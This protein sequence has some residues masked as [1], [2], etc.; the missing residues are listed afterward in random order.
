MKDFPKQPMNRLILGDCLDVMQQLRDSCLDLVYIDPPFGTGRELTG[1]NLPLA[2][3]GRLRSPDSKEKEVF[4]LM[5]VWED[6]IEGYIGWLEPRLREMARLLKPT[7]SLLVHLDWHASH[8]VK[9]LLDGIM[10]KNR[11][12]NEI[13]WHYKT[14]GHPKKRLARKHDSIFWYAKGKRY[15]CNLEAASIPRNRCALCKGVKKKINHMKREKDE[16]GNSIISIRSAG[17]TYKYHEDAP[18]PPSDVWLDISHLHQRDP[19]RTGYP[20]QKPLKLMKR[21]VRLCS[22]PGD[23]VADFFVGTGTFIVAASGLDRAWLGCDQNADA[24]GIASK[25][26]DLCSI[27]LQA[28]HFD[29]NREQQPG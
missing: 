26:L 20:A 23:M 22:N 10:G 24:L 29:E 16:A 19:E 7:G 4:R 12:I 25:R 17:K 27:P 28:R 11:F 5:D 8:Y 15:T 21:L 6:G 3:G 1:E 18:A 14:G 13:I 2:P 9:V